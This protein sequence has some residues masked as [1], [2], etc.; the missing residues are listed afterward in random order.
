M[1]VPRKSFIHCS[2]LVYVWTQVFYIASTYAPINRNCINYLVCSPYRL[3]NFC[4]L[5]LKDVSIK[6]LL[7]P[8][9]CDMKNAYLIIPIPRKDWEKRNN[10]SRHKCNIP[11]LSLLHVTEIIQLDS[12]IK[13]VG[14]IFL[15]LGV[16]LVFRCIW[17]FRIKVLTGL[18]HGTI[19]IRQN[20]QLMKQCDWNIYSL[21]YSFSNDYK[22]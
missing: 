12:H 10:K 2:Q 4:L 6:A 19:I 7:S 3:I 22:I 17:G 5:Q 21:G 16:G 14:I 9:N 18:T 8:K 1:C 11:L 13:F 20:L 15:G